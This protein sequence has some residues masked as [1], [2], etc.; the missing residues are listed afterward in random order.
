MD[1]PKPEL[2]GY[3]GL[4]Y[5]NRENRRAETSFLVAPDRAADP[6]LYRDD[7]RAALA[8]FARYGFDE[9]E[10]NR[11]YT[12]TF[13]FRDQHISILEEFGFQLEGRLRD[14]IYNN[15]KFCDSLLHSLLK[16]DWDIVRKEISLE[17][18]R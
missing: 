11:I 12:E 17:L 18:A 13:A 2:I 15:G 6:V 5:L 1:S 8:M 14:H 3:G 4:V 16:S 7:L 10:L 9:L